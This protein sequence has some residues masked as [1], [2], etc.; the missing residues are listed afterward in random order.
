[1]MMF[2]RRKIT[3]AGARARVADRLAESNRREGRRA[4]RVDD[5]LNGTRLSS[6][7]PICLPTRAKYTALMDLP[8]GSAV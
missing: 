4:I 1:M 2:Y 6:S 8:S 5:Y 7:A 3:T